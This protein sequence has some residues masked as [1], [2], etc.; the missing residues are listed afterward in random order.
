M[1]TSA[2]APAQHALEASV[3][4]HLRQVYSRLGE[5]ALSHR[6]RGAAQRWLFPGRCRGGKA[7]H[8]DGERGLAEEEEGQRVRE[9]L[10]WLLRGQAATAR[11]RSARARAR[12]RARVRAC[13]C[14]CVRASVRACMCVRARVCVCVDDLAAVNVEEL[15]HTHSQ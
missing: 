7:A 14:A 10:T 9:L 8:A 5:H 11:R 1:T 6:K 3:V 4:E 13:V 12:A 15:F 2:P